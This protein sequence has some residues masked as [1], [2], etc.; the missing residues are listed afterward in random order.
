MSLVLLV[1]KGTAAA[2]S[3]T[4]MKSTFTNSL[5]MEFV[6]VK[7]G[8]Y[9]MGTVTNNMDGIK[10]ESPRHLV[11]ITKSFYLGKFEVTQVE[12]SVL[13]GNNPSKVKGNNQPVESV[14]FED[15]KS[16]IDSLNTK[17]GH[18]RYRL[19]TEAEWEYAARAGTFTLYYFGDDK[20]L[21]GNYAWYGGNSGESFKHQN[22]GQ[23]LPNPWGFFDMHGNVWEWIEDW[24]GESYYSHSP[25]IDPPGERSGEYKVIRS[26]SS[27]DSPNLC[28]SAS[29]QHFLPDNSIEYIGF[30][31]ALSVE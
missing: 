22:V 8:K 3:L 12:Y 24:Y 23:K 27:L 30:R 15:A 17:E 20:A 9:M 26:G 2:E 14:T 10:D 5:G 19:P 1:L 7:P 21:L 6:L 18:S 25:T 31:L 13:M 28:R 29:R 11:E 4:E 16:F